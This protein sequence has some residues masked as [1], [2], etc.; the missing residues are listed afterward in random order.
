MT[1]LTIKLPFGQD[2][3]PLQLGEDDLE[4]VYHTQAH[5]FAPPHPPQE[6]V[7]RALDQ[8]RGTP[9]LCELAREKD[10]VIIITSDHT[11]PMPSSL[12][13]PM[14]LQEIRKGNPW[15]Q[16]TILIATGFHRPPT[17]EELLERFG[18][19]I[20]EEEDIFVHNAQD[21]ENMVCL[22]TLPSGQPLWVNSL[23]QEADLLLAEGFIEP[24]FFAGFSGGP[25]SVFP[26]V[27]GANSI[28]ANHC[29][30][31]LDH[32][33]ARTGI[34]D[35]NPVY[36]DIVE[37]AR[38]ANLAFIL[39]V[40]LNGQNTIINAF[41]GGF[42]EAHGRGCS[43]VEGLSR[44]EVAPKEVV[45]TTNG[46]YPLDQNLYQS[47]KGMTAGQ[48]ACQEGG[49]IIMAAECRDGHGGDAFFQTFARARSV[50]EI[51]DAIALRS[52]GDTVPDQWMSQILARVLLHHRVIMVTRA[53]RE[54][55]EAMFMKWAPS[56]EEAMAMARQMLGK[57]NPS[58]AV[59]PNGVGAIVQRP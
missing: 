52:P 10:K 51:A 34:L 5:S 4:H 41:A 54:M 45:I 55:V 13:M 25:K 56:M 47:V 21:E 59:I 22:G 2:T 43:F 15:A 9:P 44:L 57:E 39:N 16:I 32:P 20:V 31:F 36:K 40:A 26:G 38:L 46:G 23:L 1:V 14:L 49:V 33:R 35:G 29:A 12:T 42:W 17:E 30:S 24:H 11:R 8:P 3:I 18:E 53:P 27:A 48:S 37:A 50:Q 28:L 58:L 6:L 19:T 7:Q